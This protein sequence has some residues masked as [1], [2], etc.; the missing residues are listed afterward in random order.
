MIKFEKSIIIHRPVEEIWKFLS[1]V[2]NM[3]KWDRGV[4]EAKQTSEGPPGIGSTLQT[5]RQ[6]LGRRQIGNARVAEYVPNRMLALQ[7]SV[8]PITA[9]TRYT[10]EPVEG[11]TQL[12]Q[13]TDIELRGWWKLI[14]PILSPL[15][16]K[17]GRDEFANTKRMMESPA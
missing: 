7:I 16:E 8:G 6:F 14:T 5:V 9:Q 13:T 1:N 15:L 11:G 2:E 10:F 17:D 3:P 4:L 12:A